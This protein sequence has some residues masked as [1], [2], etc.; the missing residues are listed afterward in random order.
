RRSVCHSPARNRPRA[1]PDKPDTA[2]SVSGLRTSAAIR[3]KSATSDIRATILLMR[4][5]RI[6]ITRQNA[7]DDP[8]RG[9]AADQWYR[10]DLSAPAFDLSTTDDLVDTPIRSLN[11]NIGPDLQNCFQRRVF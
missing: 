3:R 10:D 6:S 5:S 1:L 9:F 4:F 8:G 11:E 2:T 7:L